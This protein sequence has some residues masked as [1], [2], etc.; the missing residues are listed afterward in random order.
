MTENEVAVARPNAIKGFMN[1][2]TIEEG[3]KIANYLAKSSLVPKDMQGRPA[4]VFCALQLGMEL[5]VSPMQAI[6][7][8]AVING[9][10]SIWGD[11][12]PGLAK[13]HPDFEYMKIDQPTDKN[14]LTATVTV[15]RSGEP[16]HTVSFSKADAQEAG[17]WGKAGPWKNYPKRMLVNRARTFAIRD[18]FPDAMKGLRTAEEMQEV[19]I[20]ETSATVV[21]SDNDFDP[22]SEGSHETREA[23]AV[24]DP[25]PEKEQPKREPRTR[26]K[27]DPEPEPQPQEEEIIPE[28]NIEEDKGP[29]CPADACGPYVELFMAMYGDR[30][31]SRF[32]IRAIEN[33]Q[34]TEADICGKLA[35]FGDIDHTDEAQCQAVLVEFQNL[36]ARAKGR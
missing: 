8:I 24:V 36:I 11:L 10:P 35:A 31:Q 7:N 22:L 34:M 6:Q 5:G 26:A 12:V 23:K 21:P 15:K 3:Y 30:K 29:V 17:L 14:G 9:R 28:H 2:T 32:V 18:V 27:K 16:E 20:R 19:E 25:E 4:D 33:A 1:P 13:A